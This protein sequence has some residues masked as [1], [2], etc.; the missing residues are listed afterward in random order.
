M[1]N[2]VFGTVG[3]HRCCCDTVGKEAAETLRGTSWGGRCWGK[4]GLM[5]FGFRGILMN[6]EKLVVLSVVQASELQNL[7]RHFF[8]FTKGVSLTHRTNSST[9]NRTCFFSILVIALC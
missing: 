4:I 8:L 6:L 2:H 9:T 3:N 5:T 7:E 1:G